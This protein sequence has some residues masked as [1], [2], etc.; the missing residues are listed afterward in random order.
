MALNREKLVGGALHDIDIEISEEVLCALVEQY[1]D[2]ILQEKYTKGKRIV[3]DLSELSES[4]GEALVEKYEEAG[5]ETKI[6]G[7]DEDQLV[8]F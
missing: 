3:V 1:I 4:V 6:E 5:W 2:Q 8:L 7:D